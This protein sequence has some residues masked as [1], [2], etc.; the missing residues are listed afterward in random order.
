LRSPLTSR[1]RQIR[2][3]CPRRHRELPHTLTHRDR[4]I[5]GRMEKSDATHPAAS[6]G[7]LEAS[8]QKQSFV[9]PNPPWWKA[10]SIPLAVIVSSAIDGATSA[11][12]YV[13]NR[14]N[15]ISDQI[16]IF[17]AISMASQSPALEVLLAPSSCPTRRS[18]GVRHWFM[19][20]PFNWRGGSWLPPDA[21]SRPYRA[22]DPRLKL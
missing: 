4:P 16:S 1:Q 13:R 7:R 19:A 8:G 9:Q 14:R 18:A 6:V 22:S 10:R 11:A 12:G 20:A 3:K 21:M 2:V 15:W 17:S 5:P